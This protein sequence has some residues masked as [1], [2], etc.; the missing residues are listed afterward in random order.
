MSVTRN[1]QGDDKSDKKVRTSELTWYEEEFSNSSSFKSIN[2]QKVQP[3]QI[4]NPH[5]SLSPAL[6][7]AQLRRMLVHIASDLKWISRISCCLVIYATT[8]GLLQLEASWGVASITCQPPKTPSVKSGL[9]IQTSFHTWKFQTESWRPVL[10]PVPKVSP[11][12]S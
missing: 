2:Y 10:L 12:E 6:L 4:R 11:S 9:R 5:R 8:K 3:R 7:F 1:P